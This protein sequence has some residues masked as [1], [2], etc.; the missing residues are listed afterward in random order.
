MI[1]GNRSNLAG[2]KGRFAM[3]KTVAEK[4]T[5]I[6]RALILISVLLAVCTAGLGRGLYLS[7][8]R[9][10]EIEEK[11][12]LYQEMQAA[13]E[14]KEDE[15][16]EEIIQPAKPVITS[17]AVSE[18]LS[19]IEQLITS[20]YLY[21][22]AGKYENRNQLSISSMTL[23][24]PLTKKS[25]VV[26][27]DGRIQAG[28]D[29][30]GAKIQVNEDTRSITVSLPPSTI[31]SHEIDEDSVQVIDE[32]DAVFNKNTIDDYNE[33]MSVQKD[34][35]EKKAAGMGLLK[36][37]DEEAKAAILSFLS[38]LPGMDTYTLT[39]R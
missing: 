28:V 21:T 15:E 3:S 11:L 18:Q 13:Q 20:E 36:K 23:D 8:Q 24:L 32:K 10:A 4:K 9:Q 19:S 37:A 7:H 34:E 5:K 14:K 30:S 31:T 29:L 27:Y 6:G 26:I 38:L 33:F 2:W 16:P 35:M 39:V 17:D 1:K 22:N 12:R 25:F